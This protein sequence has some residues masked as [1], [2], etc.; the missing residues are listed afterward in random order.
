[1]GFYKNSTI[2]IK[3]SQ[4]RTFIL[5][6]PNLGI[7]LHDF[8]KKRSFS[9]NEREFHTVYLQNEP[10]KGFEIMNAQRIRTTKHKPSAKPPSFKKIQTVIKEKIGV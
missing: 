4:S 3:V 7:F 9:T 6:I 1:M 5:A 8:Q 2:S 10:V